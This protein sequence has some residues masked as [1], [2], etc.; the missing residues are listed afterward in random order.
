MKKRK[1]VII[2]AGGKG[3]RMGHETPKQ[4]LLVQGKPILMHTIEQFYSFDSNINIIVVLPEPHVS[5]WKTLCQNFQ[6]NIEHHV[7]HGGT[8]RFYSVKNGLSFLTSS[9]SKEGVVAIHDGVR[10]FITSNILADAYKK[11]YSD[12]NAIVA[13]KS[14]DSI[15]KVVNG[16]SQQVDREE[17]YLV[18]TPQV[19]DLELLYEA[20]ETNYKDSFTDDASVF[21]SAGH[22]INLIDGSY[23]N[24]KITTTEDLLFAEAILKEKG[25]AT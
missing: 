1:H 23:K 5:Y 4:F 19:F 25:S 13:V 6:F 18:Q 2:V 8:T 3:L 14:K 9:I 17:I 11:A 22:G 15:R 12:N 10:P 24:I 20:Y 16:K 7:V 21:E